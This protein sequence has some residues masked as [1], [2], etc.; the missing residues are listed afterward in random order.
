MN[1]DKFLE[2]GNIKFKSFY[3]DSMYK[4]IEKK[5]KTG[6]FEGPSL[7]FYVAFAI[8]YHF[9]KQEKIKPKSINHVNLVSLNRDI[10][11]IMIKL[12]LKRKSQITDPKD[13]W[14]EVE[15]YAEYGIQIL[16]DALQ[17]KEFEI[18][19]NKLI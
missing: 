2:T 13:L 15:T 14:K 16:Y 9:D 8:G 4:V 19:L 5:D 18:D 7:I 3:R 12:I 6:I 11:E 1:S 10:K 17:K